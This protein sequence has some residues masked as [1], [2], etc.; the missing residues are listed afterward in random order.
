MRILGWLSSLLLAFCVAVLVYNLEN[1]GPRGDRGSPLYP[2]DGP[3][4]RGGGRYVVGLPYEVGGQWYSPAE[5][6][7]YDETGTASW[8]GPQFHRRQTAN[9]EWFDMD[10][11]T[12]AHTTLPL[13]SYVR[14]TNLEN[15]RTLVVRVNDRGP[16]V[17][18]RIIDLSRKA[19]EILKMKNK[20]TAR[21]R[22]QYIG[23]APLDDDGS[24][25]AAMNRGSRGER[26]LAQQ[27]TELIQRPLL[28]DA[29]LITGSLKPLSPDRGYAIQIAYFGN[30]EN[31]GRTQSKLADIGPIDISPASTASGTL[32]RVR[33]GPLSGAEQAQ[34]ALQ[35]VISAG[36]AD[37]RL[38][39]WDSAL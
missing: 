35:R 12:A 13:P 30:P 32:F 33:M 14:V 11:V 22:V 29:S 2:G 31:A 39:P 4:P 8:Y 34:A 3:L 20:G 16:F 23:R 17:G 27:P 15:G 26:Q 21:V 6:P 5:Q 19:A 36:Y 24:D 38:V 7:Q 28:A 18:D 1:A 9:G 10:Y 25:L 37:A